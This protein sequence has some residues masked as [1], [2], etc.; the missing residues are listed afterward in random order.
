MST[1]SFTSVCRSSFLLA[2]VE[3]A[4]AE[5]HTNGEAEVTQEHDA[6]G[7]TPI[8]RG[9]RAGSFSGID[10]RRVAL[11]SA[12]GSIERPQQPSDPRVVLVAVPLHDG[13]QG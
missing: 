2:S 13:R 12:H 4:P 9:Q 5:A 3:G 10:P 1:A 11:D 7:S 6:A 8:Y